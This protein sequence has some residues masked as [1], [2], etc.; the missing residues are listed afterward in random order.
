MWGKEVTF[1]STS[2]SVAWIQV[3]SVLKDH[4]I[5]ILL[6]SMCVRGGTAKGLIRWITV[7]PFGDGESMCDIILS[8]LTRTFPTDYTSWRG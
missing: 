1:I 5:Y 2:S 7:T 8:F 3:V 6:P 4:A